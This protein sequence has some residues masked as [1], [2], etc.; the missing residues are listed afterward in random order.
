VVPPARLASIR[1]AANPAASAPR[2]G[3]DLFETESFENFGLQSSVSAK[4][5]AYHR[6]VYAVPFRPLSLTAGFGDLRFQELQGI[7]EF[8]DFGPSAFHRCPSTR[9]VRQ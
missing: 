7:I 1:D 9:T 5:G 3:V 4:R 6:T 2:V 8:E